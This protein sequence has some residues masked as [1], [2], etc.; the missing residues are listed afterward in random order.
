[1]DQENSRSVGQRSRVAIA[2]VI[3]VVLALAGAFAGGRLTVTNGTPATTSAE[4]GFAR[5]MR[6]H[7]VQAVELS[8][9][10]RDL[11]SDADTRLLAYDIGT[12]QG[13]QSGQ[14]YG[15]LALWGLPQAEAEPS[16][17][18]MTRAAI[19]DTG[20]GGG[21]DS[22]GH[23]DMDMTGS[24]AHTPGDPMPG[25]ATA[26]QISTL[27]SLAGVPAERYFLE[28]MIAHHVGGVEMAKA[29]LE[30]SAER[31][32][33]DLARSIVASQESEIGLM[34]AMLAERQTG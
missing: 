25:L 34:R 26:A 13:Q 22:T 16:M 3:V 9:I 27:S 1:M 15:W 5:D 19:G 6:V 23:D 2:T 4:A 20:S 11:T 21:G 33:V 10:I 32:V 7:H 24:E 31:V 30:R 29:V 18:W 14:M 8:M 28:L 12:S 17:T